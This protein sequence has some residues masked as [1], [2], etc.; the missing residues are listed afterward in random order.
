MITVTGATGHPGRLVIE[1]LPQNIPATDLAA[2]VR[3]PEKAGDLAA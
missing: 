3:A 1:Y 2:A